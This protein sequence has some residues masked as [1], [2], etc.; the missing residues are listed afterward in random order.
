MPSRSKESRFR[1]KK[2]EYFAFDKMEYK[3]DVAFCQFKGGFH[4]LYVFSRT[5]NAELRALSFTLTP[6]KSMQDYQQNC[7]KCPDS[8]L[9]ILTK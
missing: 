4:I 2:D 8:K 7:G 3:G 5:S 9:P 1:R 6:A